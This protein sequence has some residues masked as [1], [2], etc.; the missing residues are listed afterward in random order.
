MQDAKDYPEPLRFSGFRF[1]DPK[2][3][4][5]VVGRDIVPVSQQQ[6]SK[7]TDTSVTYHVWGTGRMVCPGRYYA[8][9][10]MKTM[11]AQIIMKYNC[12]LVDPKAPRSFTWRSTTLPRPGV[13]VN[14]KPWKKAVNEGALVA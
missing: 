2:A 5:A 4:E 9:A 7:L 6:P 11:L 1:A 13:M 14:F 3:I 10:I 12:E 8:S